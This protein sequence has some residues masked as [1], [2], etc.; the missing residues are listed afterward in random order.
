MSDM[1]TLRD[2]LNGQDADA[3]DVEWNF[4]TIESHIGSELL[5][6]DGSVTMTAGLNVVTPTAA[7]HAT[8][9]DYV[10]TAD[11]LKLPLAGG[12]MT[13]TLSLVAGN[14]TLAAHATRKD[15][16]DA[17]IAVEAGINTTQTAAIAAVVAEVD[18]LQNVGYIGHD[19]G[20]TVDYT[21]PDDSQYST[22]TDVAFTA[23]GSRIYRAHFQGNFQIPVAAQAQFGI[24]LNGTII[25]Q[26]TVSSAATLYHAI[27]LDYVFAYSGAVTVGGAI[28]SGSGCLMVGTFGRNSLLYVEAIA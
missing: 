9:K 27:S 2:I 5:N 14:P 16:V 25:H 17:A 6:R 4:N 7:A 22:G 19:Y 15:Y 8:R 12:T 18:A 26:V 24:T 20:P 11:A 13:G 21:A 23:S 28:E 10:D 3:T 1:P